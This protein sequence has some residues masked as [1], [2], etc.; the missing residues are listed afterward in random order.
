M[1]NKPKQIISVFIIAGMLGYYFVLPVSVKKADAFL[2]IGDITFNTT[3]GD[4]PAYIADLA[5]KA[6]DVGLKKLKRRLLT[7]IQNDLINIAQ[8]NGRPIFITHPIKFLKAASDTA[9]V[10]ALDKVFKGTGIDICSPFKANV[11]FL[12][13]KAVYARDR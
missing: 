4:I 13:S 6:L 1:G 3:I 12:V 8:G 9:A 11:E 2:G 5:K 7:Q 10:T